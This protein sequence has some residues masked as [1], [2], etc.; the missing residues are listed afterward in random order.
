LVPFAENLDDF[1]M[2]LELGG[3]GMLA[4]G[5]CDDWQNGA[6]VHP[7]VVHRSSFQSQ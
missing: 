7:Q 4:A 1:E 5:D 2:K 6:G 3:D